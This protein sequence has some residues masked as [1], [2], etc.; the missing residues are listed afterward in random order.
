M[1]R[2]NQVLGEGLGQKITRLHKLNE[3][4][5]ESQPHLSIDLFYHNSG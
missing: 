3:D 2:Y 4:E 5:S 1:N